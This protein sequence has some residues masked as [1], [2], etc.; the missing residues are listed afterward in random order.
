MQGQ[1][2]MEKK[3]TLG[4]TDKEGR[5]HWKRKLSLVPSEV[6]IALSHCINRMPLKKYFFQGTKNQVLKFKIT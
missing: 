1:N 2:R 4:K 3:G 6:N 5:K